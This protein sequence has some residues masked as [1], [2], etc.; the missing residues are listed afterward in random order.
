MQVDDENILL[1]SF[2]KVTMCSME[3]IIMFGKTKFTSFN[4]K[5]T[6]CTSFNT[7][8]IN[9]EYIWGAKYDGISLFSLISDSLSL[10]LSL[11]HTH[12]HAYIYFLLA[13]S[14]CL[15]GQFISWFS[16]SVLFHEFYAMNLSRD[17]CQ[18][19]W[20]ELDRLLS[21]YTSATN[22][23]TETRPGKVQRR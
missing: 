13:L 9:H 11:S 20:N 6:H 17:Q 15:D 7:D 16:Y 4:P 1:F 5:S 18:E 10:S 22:L 14:T 12:I 21:L 23:R 3:G 8:G 19:K 2:E